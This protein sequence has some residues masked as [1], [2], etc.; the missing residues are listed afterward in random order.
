[1]EWAT[2]KE[3]NNNTGGLISL[4][5]THQTAVLYNLQSI[6]LFYIFILKCKINFKTVNKLLFQC[7]D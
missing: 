7:L 3:T 6:E 5:G 2:Q 4:R 1:M